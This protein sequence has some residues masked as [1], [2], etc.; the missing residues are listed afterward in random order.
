MKYILLAVLLIT[1]LCSTTY[2]NLIIDPTR[3]IP[4]ASGDESGQQDID[5]ILLGLINTDIEL[6]KQNVDDSP[7][8]GLFKDVYATAFLADPTD[9]SGALISWTGTGTNSI[10]GGF[11]LVKDGKNNPAWYLFDLRTS[12]NGVE[13]LQLENFW[14]NQGAISHVAFYGAA[15]VP[16]PATLLLF[17]VGLA[18]FASTR[19][20][21]RKS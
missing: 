18:S 15:P 13:T 14:P 1:S 12:W 7:D 6:Y 5:E 20:K 2:A 11:L 10:L 8:T 21:R 9:P 3:T 17:G 19:L 4:Y 16:E